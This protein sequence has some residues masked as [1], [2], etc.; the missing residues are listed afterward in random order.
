MLKKLTLASASHCVEKLILQGKGNYHW[1]RSTK[2]REW[3]S[4]ISSGSSYNRSDS[5]TAS[6]NGISGGKIR[7]ISDLS[8]GNSLEEN[9]RNK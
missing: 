5:F 1:R 6:E 7:Q 8:A 2:K 3:I 4:V 9:L